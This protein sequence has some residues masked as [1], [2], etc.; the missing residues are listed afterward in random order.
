MHL[1]ISSLLNCFIRYKLTIRNNS[2]REYIIILPIHLQ[3]YLLSDKARVL[4]LSYLNILIYGPKEYLNLLVKIS[5]RK[6]YYN[7]TKIIVKVPF[8]T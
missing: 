5:S 2:N 7:C 8:Y 4:C 6:G 3:F 1:K